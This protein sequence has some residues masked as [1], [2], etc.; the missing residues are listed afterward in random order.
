VK[1][2]GGIVRCPIELLQS[3]FERGEYVRDLFVS[4]S[5]M[6]LSRVQ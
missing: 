2:E 5:E 1:L 6:L 4:Y 3:E